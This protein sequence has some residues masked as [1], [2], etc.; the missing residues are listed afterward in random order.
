MQTVYTGL[1]PGTTYHVR[2]YAQNSAGMGYGSDVS[3][4]TT[5]TP[6]TTTPVNG[7][8]TDWT[9]SSCPTSCGQ[10]A[11]TQ[12]RSCANPAPANGGADCSGS[13]TQDCAAT[14]ECIV[15][16][17]GFC[18]SPETH[19]NC[20]TGTSASGT[21]A[22]PNWTW[23]CN[24]TNDGTNAS[25][26]EP[27]P[28]PTNLSYYCSTDGTT[29]NLSWTLPSGDTLSYFRIEDSTTNSGSTTP[30][31]SWIP[32]SMPDAGPATSVTVTPGDNYSAWV[33][34]RL[35]DGAYSNPV[36]TSFICN[37]PS[38]TSGTLL[39][40]SPTCLIASGKKSCNVTLTWTTKNPQGTSAVTSP[41]DDSGNS[42]PNFD[43]SNPD[44]NNGS[45]SVVVP[46]GSRNFYLYNPG[47][48]N[49]LA[50]SVATASCTTGTSWDGTACAAPTPP[51]GNFE[52]AVTSDG[53][54]SIPQNSVMTMSGWAADAQDGAPVAE[55]QL[56][57]DGTLIG[58]ANLGIS[59]PDVASAENNSKDL[60]SGWDLN[61]TIPNGMA[62]GSHTATAVLYDKEGLSTTLTKSFTVVAPDTSINGGMTGNL[63]SPDCTIAVGTNSCSSTI[64]WST[65]NPVATSSITSSYP[66]ADTTVATGNSS[67][68][69]SVTI[70]YPSRDFY[71]YN[72][73]YELAE[74]PQ[75]QVVRRE[76]VGMAVI[77]RERQ[78]LLTEAGEVG[79]I[80]VLVAHLVAQGQK[81]VLMIAI[82]RLRQP[83][84]QE[85]NVNWPTVVPVL[86]KPNLKLVI[87][88]LVLVLSLVL[89]HI[90]IV[91]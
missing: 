29:A 7:G 71:L 11:S 41:V 43:V 69:Q 53:S 17:N 78:Q 58:N 33:Q 81:H 22:S 56:S 87:L 54:N 25:C 62:L 40:T 76:Q 8:W 46:F 23:N 65:Q 45:Q 73:G 50:Q 18:S 85:R 80:G 5:T 16:S 49:S 2:A 3:F 15:A 36:Y 13:S 77:A 6:T 88:E 86:L 26:S 24:G 39:P 37:P 75:P 90:T 10:P 57:I 61:Y 38:L 59:R 64:S 55:V 72:E 1:T 32:E 44:A 66:V 84:P 35:S 60:D 42:S 14:P 31:S 12:T 27:I 34:T 63:S 67:N 30:N 52:G 83:R 51:F 28:S 48:T 91:R 21:E 68:G 79:V 20:S 47:S 9:P 4:T 89:L 74:I 82:I 19:Y 70:T